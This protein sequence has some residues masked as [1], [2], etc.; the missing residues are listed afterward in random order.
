VL[1]VDGLPTNE[2]GKVRRD[3]LSRMAQQGGADGAGIRS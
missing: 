2:M 1:V 3:E